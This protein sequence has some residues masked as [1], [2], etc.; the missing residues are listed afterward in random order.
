MMLRH[1]CGLEE[2]AV[3]IEEAVSQVIE[4]GLRTADLTSESNALNTIE[5]ADEVLSRLGN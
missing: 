4:D 3:A 2:E 5:I 1:S